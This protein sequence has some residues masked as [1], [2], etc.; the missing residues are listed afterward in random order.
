MFFPGAHGI[1][2]G[3]SVKKRN[4]AE[5]PC[6]GEWTNRLSPRGR[7]ICAPRDNLLTRGR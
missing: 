6:R 5:K 1:G 2:Y 4:A 7:S 3:P